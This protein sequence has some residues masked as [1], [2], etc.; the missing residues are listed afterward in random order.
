[1]RSRA[2][3][4]VLLV[5][6]SCPVESLRPCG[7]RGFVSRFLSP[8]EKTKETGWNTEGNKPRPKSPVRPA[9]HEYDPGPV[10]GGEQLDFIHHSRRMSPVNHL[11]HFSRMP[12]SSNYEEVPMVTWREEC[13]H[14]PVQIP[15]VFS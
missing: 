7:H 10:R 14:R 8:T 15:V 4:P 3:S 12:N 5:P 13:H 9:R 6:S 2:S 1:V 11:D